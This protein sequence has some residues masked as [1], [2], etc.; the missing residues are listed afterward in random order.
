MSA[1]QKPK[2]TLDQRPTIGV[3]V[4]SMISG[5][6][7]TLWRGIKDAAQ[8]HDVNLLCFVGREINSPLGFRR[9]ANAIYNLVDENNIDGLILL[10]GTI[11]QFLD[12]ASLEAYVQKFHP[13][14]IVSIAVEVAGIP[15]ILLDNYQGTS[16][17]TAH[18]IETHNCQR[19]GFIRMYEGHTEGDTRF[20]AYKDT[21]EK[22]D[23][24]FD[25]DLVV[26]GEY[27][28][29]AEAAIQLLYDKRKVSPDAIVVVNDD[30]ALPVMEQL[31]ARG[32]ST[33]QDIIIV[34]FDD[35]EESRYSDPPLTTVRQPL[36]EQAHHAMEMILAS[37]QGD[38]VPL[39]VSLS[40][41]LVL[42]ES[43]GCYLDSIIQAAAPIHTQEP[44]A[45][46]IAECQVKTLSNIL[47]R[48][49]I[50][51]KSLVKELLEAFTNDLENNPT[52]LFLATFAKIL[53]Q[54]KTR[55]DDVL[56][57]QSVISALRPCALNI[58]QGK[59]QLAAAENLIQQARVMIADIAQRH[60]ANRRLEAHRQQ[61]DFRNFSQAINI[62]TNYKELMDVV[63][64]A[65]P[66]LGIPEYTISLYDQGNPGADSF[67]LVLAHTQNGRE[68]LPLEGLA[69]PADRLLPDGFLP[70]D[71]RFTKIITPLYFRE[72]QFGFAIFEAASFDE[73]IYDALAEQI[74]SGLEGTKLIQQVERRAIQL[75]TASE[76]SRAASSILEPDELIQ[77]TVELVKERFGLYYAGLFLV[78]EDR[79]WAELRSG[80]GEP[81]K[82][83]LAE[84]WRLE[85]GGGSMIGHCI[86]TGE[87]DIQL[88]IDKAPVHLRNPHLPETKSE[89]ALPLFSRGAV[90]GALTIQSE[91]SNAFSMEDAQVLQTMANQVATSIVNAQLFEQTQTA[92]LDTETLL[93]ISRLASSSIEI[94]KSLGQVLNLTLKS[95]GIEA[96][97][98]SIVN[99]Q[100]NQLEISAHQIPEAFL[101][102]LQSNGPEGTLCDLVYQQRET[103]VAHNLA[104]DSPTDA[105]GL[106]KLGFKS[107]QGVPLETKGEIF[108]TLCTFSNSLLRP[109]DSRITLLQAIGQQVGVGIENERLFARTRET[110]AE[111]EATQRRYQLQAWS[112]YNQTRT[113]S[114][115]QKTPDGLEPLGK[116][117][118]SEVDRAMQEQTP[119]VSEDGENLKL[120]IPIMLRDQSIGAIG[121]QARENKQQWSI[122]EIT[123]AQEISE[124]F[125]LAAESI[126][127]LDETQR[128]AARERLVAEISTK[129]R[130]NNDPQIM[131]QTAAQELREALQAKRT[132]V[133]FQPDSSEP[134]HSERGEQ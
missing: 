104:E 35:I 113:S 82:N 108:G 58:L 22:Y 128:R 119:V 65:P 90:W 61:I 91:Q 68:E 8:Q 79:Q 96:G 81:G 95:T 16:D 67:S 118:I 34:G 54:F 63:D 105:A 121:L 123:L 13:L 76:V 51:D 126:R 3:I 62:T 86:T 106:I 14:P 73:T 130:A 41:D 64:Q 94:E 132:Q 24:P 52:K 89:M 7:T 45:N 83:M 114:G 131:I 21:L 40:P 115:Y 23:L 29:Q 127:L 85:V 5:Y 28:D 26:P 10:T 39:K 111:L 75:Q 48:S 122:E 133:I 109:E 44:A 36:R 77:R 18:L 27:F 33:P 124:Q 125:A 120:T 12:Q 134:D 15:S 42:R 31:H 17:V 98:F 43:C 55:D 97:L 70:K 60:Q 116:Q 2:K 99:P 37:L 80:T 93:N 56:M 74:S 47:E 71:R 100:T 101:E 30:M 92:L 66:Y 19:I 53:R 69:Y 110:L 78:D 38:T 1:K 87:T 11:S 32:I 117:K 6:Q 129:I 107:Y 112:T 88:D 84:N 46:T 49:E 57:W 72:D 50:K 59:P 4:D 20:Q 25:P 9:Q 102:T 103:I